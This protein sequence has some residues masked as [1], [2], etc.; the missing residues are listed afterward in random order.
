MFQ[1]ATMSVSEGECAVEDPDSSGAPTAFRQRP[2]SARS[3]ASSGSIQVIDDAVAD[4]S[5]TGAC[6][7]TW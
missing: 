1:F 4:D 6:G 5:L 3:L 7:W 2:I